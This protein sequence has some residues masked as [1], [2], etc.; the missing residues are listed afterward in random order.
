[1]TEFPAEVTAPVPGDVSGSLRESAKATITAIVGRRI[2]QSPEL[3]R[4]LGAAGVVERDTSDQEA[5]N[6]P[7]GEPTGALPTDGEVP[8]KPTGAAEFASRFMQ[9]VFEP[10]IAALM[11]YLPT[12]AAE[13]GLSEEDVV[14]AIEALPDDFLYQIIAEA[15]SQTAS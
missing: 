6:T 1:M 8:S 5:S 7:S 15:A 10:A 2:Q 11:D 4:K 13:D 12:M 9:E 3:A 14:T